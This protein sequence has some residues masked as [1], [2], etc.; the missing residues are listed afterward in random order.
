MSV[1]RVLAIALSLVNSVVLKRNKPDFQ[2]QK[3]GAN[4]AN[5]EIA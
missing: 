4:F 2:A 5:R 1:F 3:S